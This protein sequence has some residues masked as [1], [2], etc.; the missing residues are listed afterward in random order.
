MITIVGCAFNENVSPPWWGCCSTDSNASIIQDLCTPLNTCYNN[1]FGNPNTNSN[2]YN[3]GSNV[4][5][6]TASPVCVTVVNQNT[7]GTQW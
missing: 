4:L 2:S 3:E 6:G 5:C 7:G 1:G